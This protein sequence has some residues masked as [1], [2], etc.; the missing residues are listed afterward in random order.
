VRK[1]ALPQQL[2]LEEA[3]MRIQKF[4]HSCLLVEDGG[5]RVLLDPGTFS[6]GFEDLRG[7]T[8]VLI[9]HQHPDHMDLDRLEPLLA[10]NPEAGLY[11]DPES[12]EQLAARGLSVTATDA[13]AQFEIG[14]LSARIIGHD[15]AI[16]HPDVP[17]VTNVGYLLGGRLFHPGDALTVP[18]EPV[19]LL[20]L[21]A[22]AP[23]MKIQETV[24]Y[25]RAVAPQT[26]VPIHDA[27]SAAK[28]LY[29]GHL[30]R[31]G[32]DATT[33]RVIDDGEPVEL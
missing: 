3:L 33:L 28:Q 31:L 7:L 27:V 16:I 8:A 11:A 13:G 15:H 25:L 9:T 17:R 18:D 12:A 14:G 24:D 19:E 2:S 23:W 32:P 29:Y 22:V 6:R 4:G 26:A 20:A 30:D 1:S 21:P 5:A 10:A